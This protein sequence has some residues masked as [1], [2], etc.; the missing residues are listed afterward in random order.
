MRQLF[1]WCSYLVLRSLV[2]ACGGIGFG[3]HDRSTVGLQAALSEDDRHTAASHG[4]GFFKFFI[5][6]LFIGIARAT[7]SFRRLGKLAAFFILSLVVHGNYE[8]HA[9]LVP[10]QVFLMR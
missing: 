5:R 10:Y 2:T 1:G 3:G 7:L 8:G 4:I 6:L 9:L